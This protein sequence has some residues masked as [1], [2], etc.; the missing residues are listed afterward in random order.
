MVSGECGNG[1]NSKENEY[2][3]NRKS[4][5]LV[6][7][8]SGRKMTPRLCVRL[9]WDHRSSPLA[10]KLTPAIVFPDDRYARIFPRSGPDAFTA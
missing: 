1:S 2:A 10:V 6:G 3:A 5:T 9:S 4:K 7:L 8:A